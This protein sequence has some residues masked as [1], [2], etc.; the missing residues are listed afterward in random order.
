MSSVEKTKILDKQRCMTAKKEGWW[1]KICDKLK[2][3][4]NDGQSE[5]DP[6]QQPGAHAVSVDR[7]QEGQVI[8]TLGGATTASASHNSLAPS[9]PCSAAASSS[10][11]APWVASAA[12]AKPTT[13]ARVTNKQRKDL[14][15][16][17]EIKRPKRA[18]VVQAVAS[19]EVRDEAI[20]DFVKGIGAPSSRLSTFSLRATWMEFHEA[21]FC[22][23]TSAPAC[24]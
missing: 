23:G 5:G 3:G 13:T 16:M 11:T 12:L 19:Q 22:T 1:D 15:D 20:A 2:R 8:R 21:V 18:D 10:S 6:A 24:C 9:G 17:R 7:G 14:P 4:R